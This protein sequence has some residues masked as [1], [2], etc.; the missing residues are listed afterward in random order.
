MKSKLLLLFVIISYGLN[1]QKCSYLTDK[2]DE[3][4]SKKTVET[5]SQAVTSSGILSNDL[6]SMNVFFAINDNQLQIGFSSEGRYYV[7]YF[8]DSCVIKMES[9]QIIKLNG[10][11]SNGVYENKSNYSSQKSYSPISK[12]IV[13]QFKN[14]KVKLIRLFSY[15]QQIFTDDIEIKLQKAE[16]IQKLAS[17]ILEKL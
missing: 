5:I 16:K 12:P 1:A 11:T 9:G 17:C 8:V 7:P 4:T 10:F 3:F 13:E 2:T 6:W 14:D 15:G